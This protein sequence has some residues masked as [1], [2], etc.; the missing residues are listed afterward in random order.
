MSVWCCRRRNKA[1]GDFGGAGWLHLVH[2]CALL[3]RTIIWWYLT[4]RL[5]GLGDVTRELLRTLK[6]LHRATPAHVCTHHECSLLHGHNSPL[7]ADLVGT[8]HLGAITTGS[9]IGNPR[10]STGADLIV[11][12]APAR[13]SYLP[14]AM[15]A[16]LSTPSFVDGPPFCAS[17]GWQAGKMPSPPDSPAF[18]HY[19]LAKRRPFPG[20]G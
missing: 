11:A 18:P 13:T 3:Q 16:A 1:L 17:L 9:A 2:S 4:E 20:C 6:P 5:F 12:A 19:C 15:H 8:V 7:P 14:T 10:G